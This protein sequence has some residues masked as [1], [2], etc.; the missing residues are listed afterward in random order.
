MSFKPRNFR[1][2][3]NHTIPV[4][5]QVYGDELSYYELLNK[6]IERCNS[7]SITVNE[8]ID[9]VNHYFDSLD[10][11]QKINDKLDQM[12]QDGTLADLIN[13]KIF[14]DLNKKV[15]DN[16]S[17]LIGLIN[18]KDNESKER[19]NVLSKED[20]DIKFNM[21]VNS[22]LTNM[23]PINVNST[24]FSLS[25]GC[26]N[27]NDIYTAM[28]WNGDADNVYIFKNNDI[29]TKLPAS[30]GHFNSM[31]LAD[32]GLFI[33]QAG[34]SDGKN[35]IT[36]VS[37]TGGGN[38]TAVVAGCDN[39]YGVSFY[40]GRLYAMSGLNIM[41]LDL[42]DWTN[43]KATKTYYWGNEFYRYGGT[44]QSFCL[45]NGMCAIQLS[46]PEQLIV[47]KF[48]HD[49]GL[50]FL[51][52][53]TYPE[54]IYGEYVIGE[55]EDIDAN[56]DGF[57]ILTNNQCVSGDYTYEQV[58]FQLYVGSDKGNVG[59]NDPLSRWNA[60]AFVVHTQGRA[61]SNNPKLNWGRVPRI[62]STKT[63][64]VFQ[65]INQ[66]LWHLDHYI[67]NANLSCRID[68]RDDDSSIASGDIFR[69]KNIKIRGFTNL[70]L[71]KET[72]KGFYFV[73]AETYEVFMCSNVTLNHCVAT[74]LTKD[75][76]T[77]RH[78]SLVQIRDMI[79]ASTSVNPTSTGHFLN[80]ERSVV[81]LIAYGTS[82]NYSSEIGTLYPVTYDNFINK[83]VES[84]YTLFIGTTYDRFTSGS[85]Y[86]R[87]AWAQ[88]S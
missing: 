43:W 82:N 10:V 22:E 72:T 55:Q 29:L 40:N 27:G 75:A 31:T 7:V 26:V 65:N 45:G 35:Q 78:S 79:V 64:E 24:E 49:N 86:A 44:G 9:Y 2:W 50:S 23:K 52:H 62:N 69:C 48:D 57:V 30:L 67:G 19:D 21:S 18:Q 80:T 15:D 4:L 11:Q 66:A 20:S 6:V 87:T 12:A 41:F 53:Y 83:M 54:R 60:D 70:S 71:F 3:C 88:Q 13:Q 5:P 32:T 77:V 16:Y 68:V 76:F 36:F 84:L 28:R 34:G 81:M 47:Y 61:D 63:T 33:A 51:G 8:L 39:P 14:G 38:Y 59:F 85:F 56:A 42:S 74:S 46:N 73:L 25:C 58:A 17:E 1:E 37:T